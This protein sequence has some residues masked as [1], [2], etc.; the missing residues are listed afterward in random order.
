[1][2]AL[3]KFSAE[4]LEQC[5]HLKPEH[6]LRFLEDFRLLHGSADSSQSRLI[7]I[8]IPET[9][10]RAF[11]EQSELNGVRYQTQIKKL[12]RDWLLK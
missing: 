3:Q 11:K 2:K 12:M 1:M 10:L 7:S 6:I 4:Y 8:K 9:L 5:R